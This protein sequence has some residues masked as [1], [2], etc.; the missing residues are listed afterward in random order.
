MK[1]LLDEP[2][3]RNLERYGLLGLEREKLLRSRWING[4]VNVET[5]ITGLS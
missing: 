3:P 5:K 4:V 1:E 2:I